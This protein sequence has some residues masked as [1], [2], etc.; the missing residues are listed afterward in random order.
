MIWFTIKKTFFDLWDHLFSILII[1][2]IGI[3]LFGALLYVF[4]FFSVHPLLAIT[5][6]VIVLL[7][8]IQYLGV[9]A[10]MVREI[11]DYSTP[12]IKEVF[13]YVRE[14]WKAAFVFSF[15]IVM[16]VGKH[17]YV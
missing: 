8:F 11:A 2:F 9:V 15:L 4:Q 6:A 5:G 7:V 10:L 3:L 17:L 14:V 16:Q 12:D 13:R 1:N